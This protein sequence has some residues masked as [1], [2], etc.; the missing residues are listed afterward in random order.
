MRT[1]QDDCTARLLTPTTRLT[2]IDAAIAV[3]DLAGR[4][5]TGLR[6]KGERDGEM[7]ES[8]QDR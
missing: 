4:G 3:V 5:H 6:H 8:R 1:I 7:A 2:S